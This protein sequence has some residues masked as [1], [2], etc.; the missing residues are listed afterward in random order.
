MPRSCRSRSSPGATGS[1][2]CSGGELLDETRRDP[3]DLERG[4]LKLAQS[5]LGAR[6]GAFEQVL[7]VRQHPVDLGFTQDVGAVF[8]GSLQAL[9][10][11]DDV[12]Q[13]REVRDT[14][15]DVV[16]GVEGESR[17]H[18]RGD[19]GVLM[20]DHH[21]EERL[22]PMIPA[23]LQKLDDPG[24]GKVL[25]REGAENHGAHPTQQLGKAR[26]P[27]QVGAQ[28]QHVREEADHVLQLGPV[29]PRERREDDDVLRARGRLQCRLQGRDEHHEL[30]Y[31][32]TLR[33]LPE[34]GRQ[35]L[36]ERPGAPQGGA[37]MGGCRGRTGKAKG[38]ISRAQ[39]AR[40]MRHSIFQR[41][42]LQKL[43]LPVR[44][45]GIPDGEIPKRDGPSLGERLVMLRK[46]PGEQQNRPA[47]DRDLVDRQNEQVRRGRP[48]EEDRS[49]H[50]PSAQIVGTTDLRPRETH[51]VLVRRDF[52][53]RPE[54]LDS[55]GNSSRRS[56]DGDGPAVDRRK[57]GPEDL[58]ALDDRV[59]TPLEDRDIERTRD[60]PGER[61]VVHGIRRL[62]LT[63]EPES[64]LGKRERP[65]SVVSDADEG[66]TRD[67]QPLQIS[68]R[69]PDVVTLRRVSPLRSRGPG[70]PVSFHCTGDDTAIGT[71]RQGPAAPAN[72]VARSLISSA[73]GTPEPRPLHRRSARCPG[74]V[75]LSPAG[76][77]SPSPG[78]DPPRS[79]EEERGFR[80]SGASW[81]NRVRIVTPNAPPSNASR[82][83]CR[84]TSGS[85]RPTF[86]DEMYGGLQVTR[87]ILPRNSPER[88]APNMSPSRRSTLPATPRCFAFARASA[89]AS[90]AR[91]DA[92]TVERGSWTAIASATLPPPVQTSRAV[93]DPRASAKPLA[94]AS[95]ACPMI[96]VSMRG[97]RAPVPARNSSPMKC[98]R[99][100]RCASGIPERRCSTRV[101][102]RATPSSSRSS[103]GVPAAFRADCGRP[104][105]T[106]QRAR[107]VASGVS[108]GLS[109]CGT[110][111]ADN[112]PRSER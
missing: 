44:E 46:F 38:R 92:R 52:G 74:T 28:G 26:V 99:P 63:Q 43:L 79:R 23:G 95:A 12:E 101:A 100:V 70:T 82:G 32:L 31:V 34:L 75:P 35:R 55:E 65:P 98:W 18:V 85:M 25:V 4:W 45:V 61:H 83:S 20:D 48:H 40:P 78:P 39:D 108:S 3:G 17:Q 76:G 36:R 57:A 86:A 51:D 67:L 7:K 93:I 103:S 84:E 37:R 91:S 105:A 90:G 60:S 8:Q 72:R 112:R 11:V 5:S 1:G 33:Q 80:N 9:R 56:D 6:D 71:T 94:A 68:G 30:R 14:V 47:V 22:A 24:Q 62:R 88:N 50:W 96:S 73:R 110:R 10:R 89:T 19:G 53:C 16:N 97:I 27:C 81:I 41:R 42:A 104:A 49:Q 59:Q 66:R 2:P 69:P 102:S 54:I 13:Q 21:L 64:F 107:N 58:V 15:V 109:L 87:S 29:S 111:E 106:D 77:R